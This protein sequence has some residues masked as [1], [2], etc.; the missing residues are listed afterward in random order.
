MVPL[1]EGE[2]AGAFA[3]AVV[4]DGVSDLLS[5]DV[6]AEHVAEEGC[7]AGAAQALVREAASLA[8]LSSGGTDRDDASAAVV[9]WEE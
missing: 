3:V 4:S 2:V 6:V 9:L 1:E 8:D 7:A 5:A